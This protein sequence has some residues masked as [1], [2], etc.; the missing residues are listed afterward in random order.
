[1][2]CVVDESQQYTLALQEGQAEAMVPVVVLDDS[3]PES[4]EAFFVYLHSPSGGARVSET[5]GNAKVIIEANDVPNGRIG[6]DKKS[7][8]FYTSQFGS[9]FPPSK[10]QLYEKY[11]AAQVKLQF[12]QGKVTH[13]L[14]LALVLTVVSQIPL[15][16]LKAVFIV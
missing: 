10:M 13:S 2:C 9:N 16:M 8:H 14:S 1:L 4:A 3:V 15:L 11:R 12:Q 5:R 7:M 6:F